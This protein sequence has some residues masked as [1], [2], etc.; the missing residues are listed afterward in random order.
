MTVVRLMFFAGRLT[1]RFWVQ[2]NSLR[3]SF[4]RHLSAEKW[5]TRHRYSF[6]AYVL[7]IVSLYCLFIMVANCSRATANTIASCAY[8]YTIS[9]Q[10]TGLT[11]P[12]SLV[13]LARPSVFF[14]ITNHQPLF[15]I[16]ITLS[17]E[18]PPFF[19]PSTSFCSLSS[20]TGS[21]HPAHI[22]SSQSPPSFSSPIT[23][24][25]FHS[26]LKTHLLHKSF[27]PSSLF[28]PAFMDLNLY[29]IKGALL[30]VLVSGYVC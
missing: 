23:A 25:A 4:Q 21:P 19:I 8:L 28:L 13:T 20:C 18:S 17:V 3:I 29:W 1:L 5:S 6:Q 7:D 15:H 12:S 22:T 27:P 14:L 26:R 30:F 10:S 2:N 16:C 11:R 24:S 9:V